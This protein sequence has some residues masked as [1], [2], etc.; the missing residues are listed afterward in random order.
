MIG[1]SVAE[2]AAQLRVSKVGYRCWEKPV[3]KGFKDPGYDNKLAIFEWSLGHVTPNDFY[4]LP[5]LPASAASQLRRGM[6]PSVCS[7][8]TEGDEA[9]ARNRT[10][11]GAPAQEGIGDRGHGPLRI[12]SIRAVS[13]SAHGSNG[14]ALPGQLGL[15]PA[16]AQS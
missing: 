9:G 6:S 16:E 2:A 15:F 14:H 1:M 12:H 8:E 5:E 10:R 4:D 11:K 13:G 3:G 7:P